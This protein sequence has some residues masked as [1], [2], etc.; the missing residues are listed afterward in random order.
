M[1]SQFKSI[2]VSNQ[3]SRGII[4]NSEALN[5]RSNVPMRE[6]EMQSHSLKGNSLLKGIN[7]VHSQSEHPDRGSLHNQEIDS[8]EKNK[9]QATKDKQA[10]GFASLSDVPHV[11]R[12]SPT[13]LNLQHQENEGIEKDEA[14]ARIDGGVASSTVLNPIIKNKSL[15]K[16]TCNQIKELSKNIDS[17]YTILRLIPKGEES[18]CSYAFSSVCCFDNNKKMS[19]EKLISYIESLVSA[20]RYWKN[21]L[22]VNN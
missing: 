14:R 13:K 19:Y 22:K 7:N 16:S 18:L 11:D 21:T 9:G 6:Q 12:K 20:E 4:N 3:G 2:E 1:I 10:Q 15:I 17:P 8:L 5:D